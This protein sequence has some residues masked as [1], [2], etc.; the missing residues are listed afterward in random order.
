MCDTTTAAHDPYTM[1]GGAAHDDDKGD[2]L[3]DIAAFKA[4]LGESE[5]ECD[6]DDETRQRFPPDYSCWRRRSY[7]A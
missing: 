3:I 7:L 5:D 4:L 1:T 6:A 2:E